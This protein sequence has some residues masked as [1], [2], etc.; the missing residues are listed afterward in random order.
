MFQYDNAGN[1]LMDDK[2][3]Y[4]YD[5]FNRTVKVEIFGGNIQVN[6]YDAESLRYEMEENRNLVQ[7]IFDQEREVVT[8]ENS[9]SLISLICSTGLFARSSDS[10]RMYYHYASDEI[11]ILLLEA[12]IS[13]NQYKY[14]VWGNFTVQKEVILNRFTYYGQQINPITQ[15]YYLRA[16]FNNPIIGRFT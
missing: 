6:C 16:R 8:E 9:T 13:K 11:G 5:A 2:T 10:V 3:R 12:A 1:F 14:D 7:F 4:S 15:Q